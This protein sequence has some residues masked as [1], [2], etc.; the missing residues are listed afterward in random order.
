VVR[1]L[2]RYGAKIDH[3]VSPAVTQ[4][5]L[6]VNLSALVYFIVISLNHFKSY[7]IQD[8]H[9]RTALYRASARNHIKVVEALLVGV[10][11]WGSDSLFAG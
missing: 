1:I 6:A 8:I 10:L 11:R 4:C 2:L 5:C 3:Q 9:G 7:W